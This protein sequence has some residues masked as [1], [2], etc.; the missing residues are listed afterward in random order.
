MAF[1]KGFSIFI[2]ALFALCILF[3][4]EQSQLKPEELVFKEASPMMFVLIG[5]SL[6]II[7]AVYLLGILT[8]NDEW[9]FLAKKEAWQLA[10]TI[11][12]VI[13]YTGIIYF[14]IN[15]FLQTLQFSDADSVK[16][17]V[18]KNLQEKEKEITASVQTG[19]QKQYEYLI[20]GTTI[21]PAIA[22]NLNPAFL[23]YVIFG[24]PATIIRT[25]TATLACL[26]GPLSAIPIVGQILLALCIALNIILT[27]LN[28]A[29]ANMLTFSFM[30]DY[31]FLFYSQIMEQFLGRYATLIENSLIPFRIIISFYFSSVA[32]VLPIMAILLR[33]FP[34]TRK[35][36]NF[37]FTIAIA[38]GAVFLFLLAALYKSYDSISPVNDFCSGIERSFQFG[39]LSSCT[40]NLNLPKIVYYIPL[41][42]VIP[43]IAFS[44]S[45]TFAQNFNKI[46]DYFE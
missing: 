21:V 19:I 15:S 31:N 22:L 10:L 28:T 29:A 44:I 35:A 27:I 34:P 39:P 1:K 11:A 37:V 5:L 40:D 24:N 23:A 16:D 32:P 26:S 36:G 25:A 18:I 20:K 9:I 2:F 42:T 8:K 41:I 30:T 43:Y 7:I 38:F 45:L 12:L 4:A 17:Y 13:I 3:T 46:F 6:A 33:L 14:T